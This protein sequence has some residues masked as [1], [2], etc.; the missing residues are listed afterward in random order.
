ME[1]RRR[2]P[3]RNVAQSGIRGLRPTGRACGCP[4]VVVAVF[5]AVS[6]WPTQVVGQDPSVRA[7]AN[8]PEVNLGDEFRL[9]VEIAGARAVEQVSIPEPSWLNGGVDLYRPAIV[10]KVADP[11]VQGSV[12]S[13][14]LSYAVVAGQA[15]LLEVGPFRILADGRTLETEPVAVLVNRPGGASIV[16]KARVEPDRLNPGEEFELIAEVYGS[17]GDSVEFLHPDIFDFAEHVGRGFGFGSEK[18]WRLRAVEPGDFVVPPIRIV[19]SG[20]TYESEPLALVIA[21][22]P[23]PVE[24]RTTLQSNSIWVGGEFVFRLTV[25]GAGELDEAPAVPEAFHFAELVTSS[26]VSQEKA[27]QHRYVFRAANA[28]RFEIDPIRIVANGRTFE[29][30]RISVVVDET[31]TGD[32][33]PDGLMFVGEPSKTSA[34]VNEPVVVEYVIL[35]HDP[36]GMTFGPIVGTRSWPS[37]DDFAMVDIRRGRFRREVSLNGRRHGREMVRRIALRPRREGQ[38]TLRAASVEAMVDG[39]A[40]RGFERISVILTSD[41]H[42]LDVLPLPDEGR[43]ESFQGHVGTLEAVSWLDRTRAEVGET[44]ILQVEVSVEGLVEVLPD[45]EIDFPSGFE[46]SEP[47]TDSDLFWRGG[48][49]RGTRTYTWHLTAT[50]PGTFVIPAVEMSYFD[51]ET[52]SYGTTRSHPFTVTVLPAGPEAR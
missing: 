26:F 52:G 14:V 20:I 38:L 45:P 24:V 23:V 25:E 8:P 29:S 51:P 10:A 34:Y 49:L 43:P 28:G 40:I 7:F 11:E 30:E 50:T 15:G 31:P 27:V 37:F 13:I 35:H 33:E 44:V 5:A 41:P 1:L 32:A 21:D 16:V 36:D 46:V 2:E 12:N 47:E 18:R 19:A 3:T 4:A 6:C 42:T 9:V 39:P 48:V 22:Q 17:S